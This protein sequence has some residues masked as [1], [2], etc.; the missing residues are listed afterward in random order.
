MLVHRIADTPLRTEVVHE[1]HDVERLG[2]RH[3][4]GFEEAGDEGL[5]AGQELVLVAGDLLR[6]TDG[7]FIA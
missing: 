5:A 2:V 4:A 3:L 7:L 1:L 6:H